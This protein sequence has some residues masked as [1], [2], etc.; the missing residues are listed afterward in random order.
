ML[1]RRR[2]VLEKFKCICVGGSGICTAMRPAG[3]AALGS[4]DNRITPPSC[5]GKCGLT[6]SNS[7]VY[8]EGFGLGELHMPLTGVPSVTPYESHSRAY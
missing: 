7:A 8:A 5:V 6:N 4:G 2:F 1:L 3:A